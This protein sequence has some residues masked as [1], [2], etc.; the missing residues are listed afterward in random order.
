MCGECVL[1]VSDRVHGGVDT[2]STHS[3]VLRQTCQNRQIIAHGPG[4]RE[5][6]LQRSDRAVTSV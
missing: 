3:G 6:T 1:L 4:Q 5:R 2:A